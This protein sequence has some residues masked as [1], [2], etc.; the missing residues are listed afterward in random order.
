MAWTT[1]GTATA[2]DVLTASFWNLNVRD[3]TNELYGSMRRLAYQ[4]RT[5]FYSVSSTTVAGASDI[6]SSDLTWTADGTSAYQIEFFAVQG[7]SP[8]V[9]DT[10]ISLRLVNGAGTDLG[11]MALVGPSQ[12]T[13]R[14]GYAPIHCKIFY[15]PAAGSASINARAI[16][17]SSGAGGI[18][19]GAGG[20]N[21][22]LPMWMAVY[23]P[24]LT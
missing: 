8:D 1:P 17:I 7:Y 21:T 23:G 9:L 24:N 10:Y 22:N 19:A 15:T 20:A 6:F 4:T 11:T 18:E 13:G 14:R 16:A 5:S 3:N 2:G 12:V